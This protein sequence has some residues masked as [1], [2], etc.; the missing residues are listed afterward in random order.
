MAVKPTPLARI[1]R[2]GG[3]DIPDP[4]PSLSPEACLPILAQT[5]P[6]LLNAVCEGPTIEGDKQVY[7][8]KTSI[9]S[10]G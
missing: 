1:F 4:A 10:K 9:G 5:N 6:S 3:A 7:K 8:L 2:F